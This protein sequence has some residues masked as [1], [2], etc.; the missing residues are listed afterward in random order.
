MRRRQRPRNPFGI[1]MQISSLGTQ[2]RIFA[3]DEAGSVAMEYA[4]I[5]S[6]VGIMVIAGSNG[7]R[8]Q[9]VLIFSNVTTQLAA[10]MV[11]N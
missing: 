1:K 7:I 8:T 11:A 10:A 5:G 6:L 4:L 9:L 2:M 3:A